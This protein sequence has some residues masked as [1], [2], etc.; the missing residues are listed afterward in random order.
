MKVVLVFVSTL[1]GKITR[2]NDPEVRHWS[3][4]EDQDYY[5]GIWQ[6]S[7]LVV[8][9][10][11][12]FILNKITPSPSRLLLVMTS[13]PGE[14]SGM[15]VP[16]QIEFTNKTPS[17]LVSGYSATGTERMTVVGGPLIAT[18]F[19]REKLVDELWLTIEP[20]LFGQGLNLV[21]ESD[22][23]VRFR[24]AEV[25]RVNDSGTMITRYECLR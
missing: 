8:M 24:L 2:G 11:N 5:T 13:N 10:R 12:T 3:S 17:Q 14:Y 25:T 1:N 15:A 22:L 7:K 20:R 9:G 4:A 23:D 18:A 6:E 19:L 21:S 16:G